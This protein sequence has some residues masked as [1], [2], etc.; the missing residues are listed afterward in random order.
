MLL[1]RFPIDGL[2]RVGTAQGGSALLYLK[3]SWSTTPLPRAGILHPS[4]ERALGGWNPRIGPN[5][6]PHP[7]THILW[8]L[9]RHREIDAQI[10]TNTTI[11]HP[12]GPTGL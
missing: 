11:D 6:P 9:H 2:A 8:H 10:V 1:G 5:D 7:A 4:L 3:V 12:L